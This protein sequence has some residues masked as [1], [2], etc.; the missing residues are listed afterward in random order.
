MKQGL[1][2]P[3]RN[4]SA[5]ANSLQLC[6]HEIFERQAGASANA[7]AV[8][9]GENRLTYGELNKKAN[10]L[11]RRLK[12]LGIGPEKPVAL[13]LER[14]PLMV[15]AILG[16][17]KA[18]GAYVPI[19]LAYPRERVEFMLEDTQ[20]SVVLTQTN[21]RQTLP[22][23][24][25]EILC[26]DEMSEE[27]GREPSEPL[28]NSASAD[29]AAYI[30]YTSGSTG[31]PKGVVVTHHNVV[32][33]LK[34]TE[35]WYGFGSTDV[36][37]L[38]HSY[39][40]DVSV[41][42]L[43]GS[44]FYGGRLVVVPYLVTRNP[45]E[46][47]ELLAREKV[48]VLN[49]TPSAF[50][51]LIWA[52]ETAATKHDLSLRYVICAGEALEL[53]SLK[54]WFARHGDQKPRVVNMYGITE[55]T[56][57]STFRIIRH[58]DVLDN[59]GSVIGVPIPDL[60]LY[61]VNEQLDPVEPGT[62][63]EICVG[64]DGVARGY[65]NRPELTGQRFL[66]DPFSSVPGARLYRSGD[67]AQYNSEGEL[68]YLGR[69]DHQVK[70]R[71]FRVE[72][73]EIESDLNRH[74]GVR[75]SVVLARD[76]AGGG[77]R[78]VAYVVP[79]NGE[80]Q[81]TELREHLAQKLPDYMLPSAFVFLKKLPLTT[82]GK[83]DRR[84]LPCPNSD[85]PELRSA[86]VAPRTAHEILLAGI[87]SEVLG[88]SPVGVQDNFFELG[89]D[90]IRS[91]VLLAKA[92]QHGVRR[93]LEQLFGNPTIAGL[94]ACAEPK[95]TRGTS[96]NTSPFSLISAPDRAKLG[97]DVEDAYP[98]TRLQLGMFY[99]NE[100]DPISARYHDVF[101]YRI[102]APYNESNLKESILSLGRRHANLRTSFHLAGFSQPLQVVHQNVDIPVSFEDVSSLPPGEQQQRVLD[103]IVMEKRRPFDRSQAPLFRF[104]VQQRST[105]S[106]QLFVSFHHSCLDGWSLAA[107]VT[108]VIQDYSA[109]LQGGT[110]GLT[111]PTVEYRDFVALELEALN[112][113]T[114]RDFWSEKMKEP[115][116]STLPRWPKGMCP[117]GREQLRGP[118]LQV[119]A[120][121]LEGLKALA[122]EAGVPLKTL[123]LA[124]H[125]RVMSFVG[126]QEDVITGLISNGRPEQADAEKMAG[127]FLNTLPL[128]Q[129]LSGGSWLE[130]VR[131]TFATEQEVMPH[132]RFPLA[133]IQ[134]LAGG[135]SLFETA[136][137]FVHFHVLKEAERCPGV[138]FAEGPYF[139]ANNLTTYTTF[140]LNV[141]ST[142]LEL[143]ID[144]DPNELCGEQVAE[145]SQYYLH[146]L[147]AMARDSNAL[148]EQITLLSDSELRRVTIDWNATQEAYARDTGLA[149]L[150]A[151]RVSSAPDSPAL[152]CGESHLS[153][154]EL[155][156]RAE[157]V[158]T[159]LRGLPLGP[160]ELVGICMERSVEMV[161]ALLGILKAGGAY[162][163]LD[164]VYPGER[165]GYMIADAGVSWVITQEQLAQALPKAQAGLLFV[166][167]LGN[168][169]PPALPAR[170]PGVAF[171]DVRKDF[172]LAY[173]IYTSGSTGKPKG[174]EVYQR[175]VVNLL[176]SAERKLGFNSNDNLLAVTT[177]SFDIAA[178]ELFL[179]LLT[180]G[181]LTL[182]T[183]EQAGD[184]TQLCRLIESSK[185]TVMQGTPAT[186]RLLLESGW[187]GKNSLRVLCGGEALKRE[188]A[189]ELLSHTREVWNFYGPTE[190]TIWSTAWKVE[191]EVPVS[192]GRPLANTQLYILDQHLRPV[193][194]GVTGEL[195]IGGDGVARGYLNLPELTRQKFL[196]DPFSANPDSRMYKTGDLARFLPDGRVECL[197]R[198]DQQVKVRGFRIEPGEIET[199]LRQHAGLADALVT[200][201]EDSL[202]EKRLVGYVISKNGPPSFDDLRDFV[203]TRLPAHL[204]PAQFV[205]L[206]EFPL[207][208]NGKVDY[209]RL[210]APGAS[211]PGEHAMLRP[212][213]ED[214]ALLAGIWQEVLERPQIGI[215][216]NF[217]ELGGDSLSAT[218]AFART[219][220]ALAVDLTLREMLDRP[221]VRLLAELVQKTK[222]SS[223]ANTFTIPRQPRSKTSIEL[224]K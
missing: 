95:E 135:R 141:E 30:I 156:A 61:L 152:S 201:R 217:F 52:E 206:D 5:P 122:R 117:G 66:P 29:N 223:S 25:P 79:V 143:H 42:E 15:V 38:F 22:S 173:V 186:W 177:L 169:Q 123:L 82:N 53:Q 7:L 67:L 76:E 6:I 83:V 60:Q 68:E 120:E 132:R 65:L 202:G 142:R 13:Y 105:A 153:Y 197:G 136:F 115:N 109:R 64:G 14:T 72:L 43:W 34:S 190:T 145:L 103:W 140:M 84:A 11:A 138:R 146:A 77:K 93:S 219:N 148:Y 178:L 45:S 162:L 216:D 168:V 59:A 8:T 214:E 183:R 3:G 41:W 185:T 130:L 16:V 35:H 125:L 171:Q 70:I 54:P 1:P 44:L 222:G 119:E 199:V 23:E 158:A 71:G 58:Q 96:A 33:L 31:K 159:A 205:L 188:L 85:R 207:T 147:R 164:P 200:A 63:G 89:G 210:P 191:R 81:V 131:E 157:R 102:D 209:R 50:R 198:I 121:V 176:R 26:L 114:S 47:Y 113:D 75:E 154:A 97:P 100:L 32:R 149:D 17:L 91:I 195:H 20:A 99:H 196:A 21:R 139:E 87:W 28:A 208:P 124:A 172:P 187:Q 2:L 56:V 193:P 144:Y 108:E 36:W 107:V 39:A 88:I 166:D 127:L 155:N 101:S 116:L 218:R 184:G 212:R 62:P 221:T 10:Q 129:R 161:A 55:T 170:P 12:T 98:I 215:D 37:P 73:G 160:N 78:L 40:F 181:S 189:D 69:I 213:N 224:L 165:L 18:G 134:R 51:Q 90:S 80:P 137:D 24:G 179:P 110:A 151:Q 118:E 48:T 175:S 9:A 4:L 204:V 220:R 150:F 27:L 203:R 133:E 180:G 192:I 111:Q 128:R 104:H 46:F 194:V 106:F 126:G 167:A 174:V 19:D 74:R 163:P 211:Q 112:S 92:Q 57:H 94:A 49:Q 86:F 182:A